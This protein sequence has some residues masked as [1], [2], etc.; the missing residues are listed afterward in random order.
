MMVSTPPASSGP[1]GRF[2]QSRRGQYPLAGSITTG[3]AQP[4]YDSSQI[5]SLFGGQPTAQ[6][7]QSF[8]SA[9]LQHVEQTFS[10]SGV[11]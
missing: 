3:N 5:T 7:I 2:H 11:R 1:C 4:W 9:I 6:Q 8:D 10:L